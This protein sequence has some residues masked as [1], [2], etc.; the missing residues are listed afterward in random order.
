MK[1]KAPITYTE[2]CEDG[3]GNGLCSLIDAE[4]QHLGEIDREE[5]A[6]ALVEAY[7]RNQQ[8]PPQ[9]G[10]SEKARKIR[11]RIWSL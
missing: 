11:E 2:N 5:T 9:S 7:N 10:D 3:G 8:S 1:P 6:I 4:G